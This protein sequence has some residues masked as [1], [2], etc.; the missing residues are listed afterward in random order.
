ME[1]DFQQKSF[2]ST[3]QM[4]SE[5]SE[6]IKAY[7]GPYYHNIALQSV[8]VMLYISYSVK[9]ATVFVIEAGLLSNV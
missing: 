1:Q 9:A 5:T 7:R 8:L 6:L 2:S 4:L 3:K